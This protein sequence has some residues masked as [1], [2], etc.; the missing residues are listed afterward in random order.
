[1][2]VMGP[3]VGPEDV[4]VETFGCTDVGRKRRRNQDQF[5]IA[6]VNR[7]LTVQ[8]TSVSPDVQRWINSSSEGTVLLVA[9]GMGGVGEGDVASAVAVKAIAEYLCNAMPSAD[10]AAVAQSRMYQDRTLPGVRMGLAAALEKGD[11]EVRRAAGGAGGRRKLGTTLTM[12]YLMYPQMYVAHA[13]DSRAYLLRRQQLTQLTTDHTYAE[14]F[15]GKGNAPPPSSDWH[16]MLWNALGGAGGSAILEP[17]VRRVPLQPYDLVLL[18]SDGLTK[19]LSKEAIAAVLN[20][21]YVLS[22]ACQRLIALANEAGGSDNTTVVAARC[23]PLGPPS[24]SAAPAV[25]PPAGSYPG[26]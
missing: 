26:Y 2:P 21:E 8:S 5:L 18:C 25:P 24:S 15:R 17:E 13:G 16:H 14:K 11:A 7:S 10:S 6:Q 19:Y 1:M 20:S 9:D 4:T 23:T 22:L 12:A 3:G